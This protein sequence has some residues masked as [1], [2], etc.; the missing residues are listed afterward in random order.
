M[1]TGLYTMSCDQQL[2]HVIKDI[3]IQFP[4]A[5]QQNHSNSQIKFKF[6]NAAETCINFQMTI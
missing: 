1:D 3:V 2:V 6:W 4:H 5:S